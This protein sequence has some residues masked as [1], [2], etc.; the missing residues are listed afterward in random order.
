MAPRTPVEEVL[1][2]LW[3][4]LLGLERVGAADHFFDLGGHS[5]L[6]TRVMSRLRGAFGS[7]CLLRDLF[8]AP[9]WPDLAARVEAALRG[10]R[11][12]RPPPAPALWLGFRG[13][14][15]CPCRSRSSASGSSI[16]SNRAAPAVQHPGR[17]CAS[18]GR[19]TP[20]C[21]GSL[22]GRDRAP[23]R[24]AAHGLRR[25]GRLAGAGDPAGGP[26]RA[27]RGGSVG[28]AGERARE[29]LA[30][31]LA[32]EKPSCPFDLARGPLLRGVLLRLA[33]EDDHVV[34][35]TMHHIA[36]DGW[37]MGILVR[38]VTALYAAFSAR[39]AVPLAGA[40]GAVRGFR[41]LAAATAPGRGARRPARLVA[42]EARR[43]ASGPR[44]ACRPAPPGGAALPRPVAASSG[45][46]SHGVADLARETAAT[47][48]MILLA[49]FTAL[50]ARSSGQLDLVVGSPI[51]GRT[52]AET[53]PLIGLFLNTLA[54]R[55][56]LSG[57]PSVRELVRR[58]REVTLGAYAHQ[59]LP[60]EKLVEDLAPER[61]LSRAP[62]F[63]V[64]FVLPERPEQSLRDVRWRRSCPACGSVR[65]RDLRQRQVR[66]RAQRHRD[67]WRAG[68]PVD[69]QQRA[70]RRHPHHPPA[71]P[72]R[73]PAGGGAGRP[74]KEAL[75][76]ASPRRG[77]ALAGP[78]GVERHGDRL[79]HR[80]HAPRADRGAG[81]A[82][83]RLPW[84]PSP[85]RNR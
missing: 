38:E 45:C 78:R 69:L 17:R 58:M 62:I 71:R 44:A 15:L 34:A 28:A 68:L 5:L 4:E 11:A 74:R 84:P 21:W 49:A 47:P 22:P 26:V 59:E 56:D 3:A 76:A 66:P 2:G 6:A 70:L 46:R 52:R 67:R 13:K 14:G 53:E 31:A 81:G 72:L 7:R 19:S 75:R 24:G 85:R 30:S 1:A 60:F 35:L 80:G 12:G 48:F 27:A 37:S 39:P 43:S 29:S 50:L 20:A 10:R 73:E 61:D 25:A 42:R 82:D 8:E 51:A 41:G 23:S 32:A 55:A 65:W 16:S 18:K 33:A 63:Q 40:P 64:L 57:D 36:S 9:R 54:L 83:P 79:S 77:G